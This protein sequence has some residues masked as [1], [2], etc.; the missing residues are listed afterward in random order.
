MARLLFEQ[1]EQDEAQIVAIEHA[2]AA[3]AASTA[4]AR[5]FLVITPGEL[6]RP[7]PERAA[8]RSA[9]VMPAMMAITKRQPNE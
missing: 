8:T 9:I 2:P 4:E 5:A 3:A 6:E 1:G 7:A